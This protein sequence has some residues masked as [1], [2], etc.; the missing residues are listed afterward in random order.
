MG[1]VIRNVMHNVG[2]GLNGGEEMIIVVPLINEFVI[3]THSGYIR[4]LKKISFNRELDY[5]EFSFYANRYVGNSLICSLIDSIR[6]QL[7]VVYKLVDKYDKYRHLFF[8]I[9]LDYTYIN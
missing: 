5:M 1:E 3:N 6:E 4:G 2:D 8:Y 7:I 9:A